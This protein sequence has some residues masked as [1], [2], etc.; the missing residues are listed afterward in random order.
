M[1]RRAL[2]DADL[3]S[4][5]EPE[6]SLADI[7]A[8]AGRGNVSYPCP[9]LSARLRSW[10]EARQRLQ[11]SQ[12]PSDWAP[13]LSRVLQAIG[14]PGDRGLNSSEYQTLEVWN[15]LLSE[16]AGLDSVTGSIRWAPPSECCGAW[17]HP[18]N[19]SPSP[20]PRRSRSWACSRPRACGSTGSGYGD[21]RQCVAGSTCTRPFPAVSS[22]APF[23]PAPL[24]TGPGTGVHSGSHHPASGER[25]HH[26]RGVIPSG[27][28]IPI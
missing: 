8:M 12:M 17:L 28:T 14:W 27:K 13:A 4:L 19:F 20:N 21:A 25:P 11:A 2:L 23:Q 5:G 18:G 6:V 24:F 26:R 3:R 16:L 10:S 9:M 1:T 22:A 7:I 15:E